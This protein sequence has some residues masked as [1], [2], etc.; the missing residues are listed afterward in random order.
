[1]DTGPGAR[2]PGERREQP[3]P[4]LPDA[5]QMPLPAEGGRGQPVVQ[6]NVE[7]DLTIGGGSSPVNEA[8]TDQYGH[9]GWRRIGLVIAAIVAG[10]LIAMPVIWGFV[11]LLTLRGVVGPA[12]LAWAVV[13]VL[14]IVAA[15]AIG[16]RLARH[17][18]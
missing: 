6:I 10:A 5:D 15:F 7:D 8:A 3:N 14:L 16:V 13:L 2:P 12:I 1:M 4:T 11:E 9:G 18:L 17:G